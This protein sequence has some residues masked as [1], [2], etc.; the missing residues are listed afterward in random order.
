MNAVA[1][2][3][4]PVALGAVMRSLAVGTVV[5]SRHPRYR[6]GEQVMGW[7]GWQEYAVTDGSDVLRKVDADGL[8]LSLSLGVLGLKA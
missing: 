2:Y 7:F 3:A 8:P 5:E 1:N 4:E 6:V